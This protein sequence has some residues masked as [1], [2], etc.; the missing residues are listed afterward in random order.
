MSRSLVLLFLL[1]LLGLGVG[2]LLRDAPKPAKAVSSESSD[3]SR[4]GEAMRTLSQPSGSNFTMPAA[5]PPQ[6]KLLRDQ[7]EYLQDQVQALQKENSQLIDKLASITQKP[8]M[9][10]TSPALQ[11]MPDDVPDFVGIGIE[12]LQTR[13]CKDVPI[14]TVSVN[15]ERVEQLIAKWLATQFAPQHGVLQGRALAALGA[16]PEPVDTLALKA[17]FLSH[18]IGGWYDAG[19]QTLCIATEPSGEQGAEKENALALAYGY[20]FKLRGAK[21]FTA[22]AP[23]RTLDARLASDAV[24]AGDAALTRFLH[25]IRNPAQGGGGGVG[26]DPDDPSRAVPIPNFLRQLELL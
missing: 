10:A 21:L 9:A 2:I 22:N 3:L 23:P 25:A 24:L 11:Q 8:E 16:I 1:V 19:E 4:A 7:V 12:L 15:R 17:A 14:P 6:V 18:Q 20:L 5:E 26:E 13:G